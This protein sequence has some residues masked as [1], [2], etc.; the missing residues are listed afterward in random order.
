M[1]PPKKT[2]LATSRR[3]VVWTTGQRVCLSLGELAGL[4][5]VLVKA[6]DADRWLVHLDG[7]Q[8]GYVR[9]SNKSL[10][11]GSEQPR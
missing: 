4:Q 9:I 10:S 2:Q 7:L 6:L 1:R 8:G 11:K 5:G 3:A